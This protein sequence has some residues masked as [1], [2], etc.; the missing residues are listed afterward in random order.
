[1]SYDTFLLSYITVLAKDMLGIVDIAQEYHWNFELS[2]L[3][4][5]IPKGEGYERNIVSLC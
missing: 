5:H 3:K 2:T 4:V 1:M